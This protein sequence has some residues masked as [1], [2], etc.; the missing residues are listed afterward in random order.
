[1]DELEYSPDAVDV[2]NQFHEV[3]IVV[4]VEGDSDIFFWK[5]LFETFYEKPV[6]IRDVGGKPNLIKY[7][8]ELSITERNY[9]VAMD[10]DYDYLFH[11]HGHNKV[12][13]TLGH[14][15]ENSLICGHTLSQVIQSYALVD[16]DNIKPDECWSWIEEETAKL[17]ELICFEID[18]NNSKHGKTVLGDNSARH[19]ENSSSPLLCQQKLSE[20]AQNLGLEPREEIISNIDK[21]IDAG[22][23]PKDLVRGHYLFT[24]CL[25]YIKHSVQRLRKNISLSKDA[26]FGALLV[27]FKLIFSENHDHYHYY[28]SEFQK[29]N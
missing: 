2:L 16:I 23:S 21:E 27:A 18:N 11:T 15:I 1:M 26:L 12:L 3:N 13:C 4:L 9:Y 24:M 20:H 17:K 14:S 25:R 10:S 29:I 5:Y 22:M 19:H 7:I 6:K 8:E 28:K